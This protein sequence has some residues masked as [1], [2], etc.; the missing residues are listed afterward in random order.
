LRYLKE[1]FRSV[2]ST[3]VVLETE[4]DIVTKDG[5]RVYPAHV[6]L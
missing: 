4:K 6:F 5:I 1:R 3:Q 2:R